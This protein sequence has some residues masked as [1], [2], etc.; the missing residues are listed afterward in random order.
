MADK[1]RPS[2][3]EILKRAR[4]IVKAEGVSLTDAMLRAEVELIPKPEGPSPVF[5]V[6]LTLKPR[7]AA[8]VRAVFT[9]M[10]SHT[11]EE[12]LAVYLAA[13]LNQARLQ[14]LKAGRTYDKPQKG[15]AVTLPRHIMEQENAG[16]D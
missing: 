2:D 9:P 10:E 8:W 12:R 1:T 7:V 11:T 14:A 4:Q 5:E 13:L 15:G 3:D 6:T 16:N